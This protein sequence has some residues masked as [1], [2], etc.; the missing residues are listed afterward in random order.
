MYTIYRKHKVFS[1]LIA[2]SERTGF[3][4]DTT[5]KPTVM[6][7]VAEPNKARFK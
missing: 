4:Q 2:V 1:P 3:T 7:E 5:V 6:D